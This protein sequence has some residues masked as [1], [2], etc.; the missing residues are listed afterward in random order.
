VKNKN[1]NRRKNIAK[2]SIFLTHVDQ[3]EVVLVRWEVTSDVPLQ[4][5]DICAH[6]HANNTFKQTI[7]NRNFSVKLGDFPSVALVEDFELCLGESR[8]S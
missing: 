5:T 7:E 2:N 8:C 4:L 1:K 6:F 3:S